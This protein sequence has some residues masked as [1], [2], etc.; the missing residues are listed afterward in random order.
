LLDK[1]FGFRLAMAGCLN[2]GRG[3][4]CAPCR[5]KRITNLNQKF[6]HN[7]LEKSRVDHAEAG[8][9]IALMEAEVE[10]MQQP[11]R[12]TVGRP[13]NVSRQLAHLEDLAA[14]LTEHA[15]GALARAE[16]DFYPVRKI[17]GRPRDQRR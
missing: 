8:V 17:V 14:F 1:G 15:H 4:A 10:P 16:G 13:L 9:N 6:V 3:P 11:V 12:K 5:T 7:F 2:T